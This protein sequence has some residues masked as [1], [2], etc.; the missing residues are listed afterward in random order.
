MGL[1]GIDEDVDRDLPDRDAERFD[2]ED[3]QAYLE[4]RARVQDQAE[5]VM[6]SDSKD[7][8]GS[9]EDFS[10]AGGLD[11]QRL[12][13]IYDEVLDELLARLPK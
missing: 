13:A 8:F 5:A 9:I 12:E 2:A 11:R 10:V 3:E 7:D 4:F 1:P 6:E